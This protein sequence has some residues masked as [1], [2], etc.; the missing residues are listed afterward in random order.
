MTLTTGDS[1]L[2][3]MPALGPDTQQSRMTLNEGMR[4]QILRVAQGKGRAL[5]RE[6]GE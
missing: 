1:L 3:E 2:V 4:E 6:R 5:R